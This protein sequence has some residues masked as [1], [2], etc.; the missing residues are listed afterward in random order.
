M[1]HNPHT[2]THRTHFLTVYNTYNTLPPHIHTDTHTLTF[3][4]EDISR[5]VQLICGLIPEGARF[6]ALLMESLIV[7][8]LPGCQIRHVESQP[9]FSSQPFMFAQSV[10]THQR[11][12]NWIGM[13]AL[14]KSPARH[15]SAT[16][17]QCANC[18]HFR[19]EHWCV[20][21]TVGI[22]LLLTLHVMVCLCNGLLSRTAPAMGSLLQNILSVIS[23]KAVTTL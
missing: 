20:D 23:H 22:T 16:G 10:F 11:L 9:G 5:N 4:L 7:C 15:T 6:R 2:P 13:P 21:G 3:H 14:K 18:W 12:Q 17:P 1:S 19:T 8:H